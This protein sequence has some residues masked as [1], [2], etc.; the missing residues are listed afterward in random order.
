MAGGDSYAGY[1]VAGQ[2]ALPL[3]LWSSRR[4]ISPPSQHLSR[5]LR[6]TTR[7]LWPIFL[8]QIVLEEIPGHIRLPLVEVV[9]L[10]PA[11]NSSLEVF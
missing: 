2:A 9:E 5:Q 11:T 8:V 1:V 10:D 3:V 6:R 4:H 7:I